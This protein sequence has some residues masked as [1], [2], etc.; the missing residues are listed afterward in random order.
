MKDFDTVCPNSETKHPAWIIFEGYLICMDVLP[1][2]YTR[3]IS[4]KLNKPI[5][6]QSWYHDKHGYYRI[7]TSFNRAKEFIF[8]DITDERKHI[9]DN[10]NE[11]VEISRMLI[12]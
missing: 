6:I 12:Q 1:D 2:S 10:Y 9:S 5:F 4:W 11:E 3:Y 7:F 8:S